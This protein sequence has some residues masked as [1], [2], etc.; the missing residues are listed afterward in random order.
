MLNAIN[1]ESVQLEVDD[2]QVYPAG[3]AERAES[4]EA[5]VTRTSLQEDMGVDLA[6]A[7]G[8]TMLITRVRD[9]GPV[10]RFN[11]DREGH[12][13]GHAWTIQ[14]GDRV[15][16]VNGIEADSQA[17]MAEMLAQTDLTLTISRL[18]SF[19]VELYRD[20]CARVGLTVNIDHGRLV[21]TKVVP[22][23]LVQ[24]CW[25][26]RRGVDQEV[27]EDLLIVEVNGV[28]GDGAGMMQ[29]L[30][31]DKQLSFVVRR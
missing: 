24:E 22:Q 28:G 27:R 13:G 15:V 6:D 11:R 16:A 17:M 31:E 9:E 20:A 3:S 19:R 10:H 18:V 30:F 7:D 21:I 8:A 5:V 26:R 14:R 25:N 12:G 23:G 4:F 29:R 2:E 1:A